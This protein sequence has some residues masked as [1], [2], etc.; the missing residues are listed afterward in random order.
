MPGGRHRTRRESLPAPPAEVQEALDRALRP[1]GDR[2]A[3]DRA[4]PV[5]Q[6]AHR[7]AGALS[8]PVLAYVSERTRLPLAHLTALVTFYEELTIDPG[9]RPVLRVCDDVAC[10]LGGRAERV[11]AAARAS[12]RF[13]VHPTACLGACDRGPAALLEGELVAPVDPEALP[14]PNSVGD[15]SRRAPGGAR[16]GW[17]PGHA[18][19]LLR[20][21]GQVDPESAEAYRAAGGFRGLERALAMDPD[22]VIAAVREAG[23]L[24][25]GGAAFPT[26]AKWEAARRA[27]G[28]PKYVVVNADES[29]PGAYT[30]R[31][32]LEEDPF[33][34]LEGM[35]I[36]AHAV[37][38]SRGYVYVRGEYALATRRVERALAALRRLGWLGPDALGHGRPFDVELR[39]G[40]GAYV[41][42]EE[43]ALFAS[44][45]GY[46]GEPR[47]KP[48]FPTTHGL[49]GKP[50]VVQNVETL[51]CVTLIL[52]EG[53]DGFRAAQPKL[54]SVSGHVRRPGVY[55]V[56][57][58]TPL[59]RLLEDCA[60]GVEGELQAVLIGGAAG[61]FLR[62]DQIDVPLDHEPLRAAGA[63]LGAGAVLVLN[64][65][66]DLWRDVA[67]RVA[68]FFADESCGQCVPCRIGTA[69]QL[70]RVA[71]M[72]GR[73]GRSDDLAVLEQLGAV[74]ADASICGLGQ[75]ASWAVLSLARQFGLPAAPAAPAE[76]GKER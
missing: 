19:R 60:G 57:L 71:A 9:G 73:G 38:A 34:V 31:K 5:L 35:L 66:V 58:G 12:G 18:P 63:T 10:R 69:R 33:A 2:P 52:A 11:L 8:P 7:A 61:M 3:R 75:S 36:A 23:L 50:T 24:G 25:R 20:R 55:E 54:F 1:F 70:E 49:F 59:R 14:D 68:R 45:E 30:N 4:L 39:R 62:P 76:G 56:P 43:T 44:I 41:C 32:L 40:A 48:P 74:M 37:G 64:H 51:A 28:Q 42:G 53:P 22:A 46:R 29:E 16:H 21:C 13:T 65:T 67:L 47:P 72:A 17:L 27:P 6:A 26:G 15:P